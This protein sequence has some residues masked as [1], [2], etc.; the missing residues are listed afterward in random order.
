M[1]R[2]ATCAIAR[3][4]QK[5]GVRFGLRVTYEGKRHYIALGGTWEGWDEERAEHERQLVATLL[6]R[7]EW[8][9]P[10][11][12]ETRPAT[13]D[14]EIGPASDETFAVVAS[15]FDAAHEAHGV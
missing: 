15:R 5:R 10:T 1:A 9:P 4:E 2:R 6:E 12:T 3:R 7:G 14:V 11:P 13:E 8:T